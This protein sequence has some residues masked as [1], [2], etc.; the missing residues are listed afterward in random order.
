M[1]A[2]HEPSIRLTFES[3]SADWLCRPQRLADGGEKR[4]ADGRATLAF[5]LL[6]FT[7]FIAVAERLVADSY[8]NITISDQTYR[9]LAT[10]VDE[11]FDKRMTGRDQEI[12]DLMANRQKLEAE[13]DKLLAAHF[14]DAD[15]RLANQSFYARLDITDD[16]QLRPKLAEPFAAIIREST[17]EDDDDADARHERGAETTYGNTPHL[18]MSNVPVRHFGW[19]WLGASQTPAS[20]CGP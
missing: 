10:Q 18:P 2:E 16:E 14:A 20:L 4:R 17:N 7:L 5:D 8:A 9:G 3:E 19:T 6:S 1:D 13:S 12:A 11:A 15:R